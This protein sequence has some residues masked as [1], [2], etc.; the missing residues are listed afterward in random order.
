MAIENSMLGAA[1]AAANP[2]TAHY[3]IAHG[4]AVGLLL[5]HVIRFNAEEVA[6]RAAYAELA[7]AADVAGVGDDHEHA[8]DLLL[9]RLENVLNLASLPRVL[10][11]CGVEPEAIPTL[12]E[13]AGR[14]WTANF[15]PRP[16]TPDHFAGLYR[17]AFEPRGNGA[18]G[19]APTRSRQTHSH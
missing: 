3:G 8:L 5:P 4:E 19:S 10:A 12:A 16:L 7:R 1:H 18:E 11:D 15:N 6:T 13:E 2:L 14:Q 9:A 17:S